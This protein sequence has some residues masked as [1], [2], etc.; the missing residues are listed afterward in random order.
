MPE[1][2]TTI[3]WKVMA[4]LF[5]PVLAFLGLT[6]AAG[7]ASAATPWHTPRLSKLVAEA[8]HQTTLRIPYLYG[9]GH[10]YS[11]ADL[12]SRVDCSGLV[13]ELYAYAFGVDI[14]N[15]SGDSIIR[16]SGKFTKTNRPVPGDVILV[17]QSGGGGPAE[18]IFIY[19]G[20]D[21]Q[22]YVYGVGSPHTGAN[23]EYQHVIP[24]HYWFHDVMG[25][26]HYNGATAADSGPLTP[27]PPVHIPA[28][29]DYRT[30]GRINSIAFHGWSADMKTT[31]SNTITVWVDGHAKAN[32]PANGKSAGLDRALRLGGNHAFAGS[33]PM[34][35]G[36]HTVQIVAH[37]ASGT[38]SLPA[39]SK[40][41]VVTVAR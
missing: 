17:G 35:P 8:Q 4:A 6:M 29:V 16:T 20:H 21:A 22:G 14:G 33:I 5:V 25:Y 12:N 15:G 10:G 30:T 39:W 2:R 3:F 27:P 24:Q 19:V 34:T 36:R 26:W 32:F 1:R 37:A 38:G 18:H 40:R 41:V 9:G 11:P 13:R 31:R 28:R 7:T 23:V